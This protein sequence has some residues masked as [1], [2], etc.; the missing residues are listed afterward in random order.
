MKGLW[1]PGLV[2]GVWYERAIMIFEVGSCGEGSV[3]DFWRKNKTSCSL[4]NR[5]VIGKVDV[6]RDPYKRD[7]DV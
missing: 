5:I 1:L 7:R 4:I 2:P 3:G 6:A